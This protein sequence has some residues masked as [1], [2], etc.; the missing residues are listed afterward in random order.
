MLQ[1]FGAQYGAF[2][3]LAQFGGDANVLGMGPEYFNKLLGQLQP[4]PLATVDITPSLEAMLATTDWSAS[5]SVIPAPAP[6]SI[7]PADLALPSPTLKRKD[8]T[9]SDEP[10][11]PA[12]RPRGRP[13]KGRSGTTSPVI[14]KQ[15]MRQSKPSS[16]PSTPLVNTV[17]LEDNEEASTRTASGKP[18][19]ARPKSVVPEKYFKDGTAQTVTGMTMEQ[20][21]AFPTYDELLKQVSP[22]KRAG[23]R[24][25]GERIAENRDKAKDAAKKSRDEKRQK[26]EQLEG[27][28]DGL[29][30]Q[31]A[32]MKEYLAVLLGSGRVSQVEVAEFL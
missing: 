31:V 30:D 6:T 32:R 12:K 3:D 23:A 17:S 8:S 19:T 27:Q 22:E 20:I 24:E 9:S 14:T 10:E 29:E 28:V 7:A 18:S 16:S 1:T 13:P 2:G 11:Q 4:Q 25:F 5:F 15:P 26:I 21:L